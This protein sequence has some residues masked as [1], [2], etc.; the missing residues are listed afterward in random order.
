[1]CEEG[2]C[3]FNVGC[4][5]LTMYIETVQQPKKKKHKTRN[6]AKKLIREIKCNKNT[7]SKRQERRAGGEKNRWDQC[8]TNSKMVDLTHINNKLSE[9]CLITLI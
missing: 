1:M 6:I 8:K 3:C 4:N 2:K 7:K 5:T 9:N